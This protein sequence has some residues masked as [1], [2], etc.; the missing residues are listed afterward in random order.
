MHTEKQRDTL[1]LRPVAHIHSEFPEK[2][3]VPRQS[4]LVPELRAEIVFTPEFRN[5]DALRGLADFSHLW[6]LW[7]FS[8]VARG[9]AWSPTVR[10]PRLGGNTRVG[11]FATR[12]PFRPNPLGLSCVR[13]D[14]VA[15]QSAQG[16]LLYVSGAD[17]I[18]ATPIYDLKP[19]LPF[20][21]SHPEA[22]GSFAEAGLSHRLRVRIPEAVRA[23]IPQPRFAALCAVL[24][25][26]PRPSYHDDPA[27][28][29]GLDFAG[30]AVR[31]TVS[32]ETL[33][34]ISVS[35]ADA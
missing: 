32:G 34:V 14:G 12:S 1:A 2:F 23:A 26:D 33:T 4:G 31:F 25:L 29:Y 20:T 19:Y 30:L 10:P 11:M 35:P 7:G 22:R 15:L 21:D 27:R 8:A 18:D 13:L 17:L 5:A 6:L 16:P 24:A 9:E 28:V 3:G